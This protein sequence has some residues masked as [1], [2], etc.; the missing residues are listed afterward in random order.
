LLQCLIPQGNGFPARQ[1]DPDQI[2]L[3]WPVG[4]VNNGLNMDFEVSL[5]AATLERRYKRFLADVRLP[6][7]RVMTVHC[8][9]TGAMLGCAE[10]GSEIWLSHSDNPKRKYAWTWELVRVGSSLVSVHPGRSNRLVDEAI[11]GGIIAPLQGYT[12]C[13]GEVAYGL[14]GSRADFFLSGH[15]GKPDC[16]LE[17][18]N[19]TALSAPGIAIFPDAMSTRGSRHLREL[20]AWSRSGGRA[21]LCFCVARDDAGE[22]RPADGIDPQYGLELRRALAAGVEVLAYR[23]RVSPEG[24]RLYREVPVYCPG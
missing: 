15:A 17:V 22:V 24:I 1:G 14:E 8:P 9:N 6:D 5:T 4:V 19:V 13:R 18:K 2:L 11:R 3:T 12:E 21:A 23:A 7:G 16:F 10:P 20:A